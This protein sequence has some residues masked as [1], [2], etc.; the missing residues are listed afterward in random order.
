MR[1]VWTRPAVADLEQLA[2]FW[3]TYAPHKWEAVLTSILS[4]V[5]LLETQPELG[6]REPLLARLRP[7]KGYRYALADRYKI[8]YRVSD[9]AV[10]INQVFDTRSNPDKLRA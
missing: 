10:V 3:E 4:K 6:Q 1:I 9:N 8:I 5:A 2:A 7:E